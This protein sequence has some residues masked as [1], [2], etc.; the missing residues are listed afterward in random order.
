VGY[1]LEDAVIRDLCGIASPDVTT[2]NI[3]N[4]DYFVKIYSP[5]FIFFPFFM[6]QGNPVRHFQDKQGNQV[7]YKLEFPQAD[8]S[9][10]ID[11][12]FSYCSK[13]KS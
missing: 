9:N 5:R 13:S 8:L 12:I 2:A 11:S 7:T 3:N 10:P 4:L 6:N 1:Y